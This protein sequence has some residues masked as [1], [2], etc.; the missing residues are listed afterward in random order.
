MP[1]TL[2]PDAVI[3]ATYEEQP[4]K[5]SS[6]AATSTQNNPLALLL[7]TLVVGASLQ[8]LYALQEEYGSSSRKKKN[9][10]TIRPIKRTLRYGG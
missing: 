9:K 8:V 4:R 6:L 10:K 1:R 3:D 5:M 7:D 2:E